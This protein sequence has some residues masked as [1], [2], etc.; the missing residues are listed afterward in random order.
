MPFLD[1]Q[2]EFIDISRRGNLNLIG[3]LL[4]LAIDKQF[5]FVGVFGFLR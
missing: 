1:A 5:F 3:K 2:T 4:V